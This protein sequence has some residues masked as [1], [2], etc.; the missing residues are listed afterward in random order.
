[1]RLAV[2]A[3]LL[4]SAVPASVYAQAMEPDQVPV[5]FTLTMNPP[6]LQRQVDC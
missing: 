4:F 2:L 3:A 1:M 6:Y 5:S